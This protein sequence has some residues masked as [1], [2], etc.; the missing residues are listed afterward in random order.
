MI[1]INSS[2]VLMKKKNFYSLLILA[3][4]LLLVYFHSASTYFELKL[5]PY[6]DTMYAVRL[7]DGNYVYGRIT[8]TDFTWL[9]LADV[10]YFQ[11][12]TVEEAATNNLVAQSSNTLIEPDNFMLINKD[13]VLSIERVGDRAKLREVIAR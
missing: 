5:A 8:G 7:T 10:Y 13:R 4:A 2:F 12:L 3:A 11:T 6:T 1:R 9:R